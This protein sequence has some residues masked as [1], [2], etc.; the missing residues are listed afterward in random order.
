MTTTTTRTESLSIVAETRKALLLVDASGG[1]GW[2]QRRWAREDLTVSAKTWA[3]ATSSFAIREAAK[4]AT[5]LPVEI[6]RETEKAIA[7]EATVTCPHTHQ[8]KER[9]A[10]FP[11][12]ILGSDGSISR[13]WLARKEADLR[14]SFEGY[15]GASSLMIEINVERV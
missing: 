14:Q 13:V 9:L 15:T 3:K 4:N 7:V 1:Q 6:A 10:W 8:S 11:K 12:S 2:V 5:F